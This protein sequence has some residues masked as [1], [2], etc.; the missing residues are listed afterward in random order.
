MNLH[1]SLNQ[2]FDARPGIPLRTLLEHQDFQAFLQEHSLGLSLDD[3]IPCFTHASF[4]HEYQIPS[5][6]TLEF[7]G[8][9][10]LQLIISDELLRLY[11][12]EKEGRLSKLRSTIVNEKGLAALARGL[13]LEQ[14][15]L[16]GKG[17]FRKELFNQDVVLAD[18]MEALVGQI[19]RCQGFPQTKVIVLNWFERYLP[20][21]FNLSVLE[22]F[23]S[24]SRLQEATLANYKTLPRYTAQVSPSG[25]LVELWINEKKVAEGNFSSKKNGERDLAAKALKEKL[26]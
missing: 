20:T 24:K 4:S 12:D 17:E 23:D 8:D 25:F 19:Y 9:A 7:L 22:D 1:T 13:K 18:T 16:V 6:E 2:L 11:P 10:V 26:F 5:Q 21:V 14:L 15:I 3:L